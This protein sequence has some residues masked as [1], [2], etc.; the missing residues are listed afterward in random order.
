[1]N[2]DVNKPI[3]QELELWDDIKEAIYGKI[4]RKVGNRRYLEDWSKDVNE[5]AQRYIRWITDR[6]N[7]KENPI[8]NE[9]S[10][11]VYSLQINLNKSITIELAIEML[12]QH[13]ITKP[14]FE[15]LFDQNS[16][17]NNNPV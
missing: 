5:I 15:A 4:V 14:V 11:F 9:F 13:L 6:I 2:L 12:A 17:V 8:K 1:G 7:D 10:K 16:F 3:Q